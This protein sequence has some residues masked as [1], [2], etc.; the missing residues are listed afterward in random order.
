MPDLKALIFDV[1]GTLADTERDGHRVAFNGAFAEAGLHWHWDVANYGHL[2]TT[3]GGKERIRRYIAEQ[4]FKLAPPGGLDAFVAELHR[5]KTR[6]F[7]AMLDEGRIPLR[8]GVERLLR[9]AREEGVAL[10]IATTTTPGNVDRLL[11]ATLGPQAPG[12]FAVIA[13]GD[14]VPAK[15]P[16]PDIYA[17]A[18]QRLDLPAAQC[19]ALEDSANGVRAAGGVNLTTVVT[20]SSY[21]V[22]EDFDGAAL[23]LSDFG[24]PDRPFRVLSGDAG[25]ARYFDIALARRLL[26]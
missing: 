15:K 24:E 22:D 2:L 7:L 19:L 17:L 12:W 18:L 8:P 23:V 11:E 26:K 16:A 21:T 3:T 20:V 13:A 10:A 1:D 5:L 25:D 6:Y 4:G 9:E 14:S